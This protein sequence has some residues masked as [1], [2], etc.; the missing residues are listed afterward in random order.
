MAW[1]WKIHLVMEKASKM[2]STSARLLILDL[3][4]PAR[5][6]RCQAY[7]RKERTV[8]RPQPYQPQHVFRELGKEAVPKVL[9]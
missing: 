6:N 8:F 2:E 1:A 9:M 4:F 3:S 7:S 5:S